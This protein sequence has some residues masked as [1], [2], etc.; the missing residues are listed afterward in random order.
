[1]LA[2][3]NFCPVFVFAYLDTYATTLPLVYFNHEFVLTVFI[4][5]KFDSYSYLA[6]FALL[7]VYRK[8]VWLFSRER[9]TS[10]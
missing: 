5:T 6:N 4:I 2:G 8:N 3:G 7:F 10:S 1:M 9:R